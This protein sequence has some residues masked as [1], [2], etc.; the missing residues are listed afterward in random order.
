MEKSYSESL[1]RLYLLYMLGFTLHISD[2]ITHT[3]TERE[4]EGERESSFFRRLTIYP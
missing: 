1:D 3:R 2:I 4:R